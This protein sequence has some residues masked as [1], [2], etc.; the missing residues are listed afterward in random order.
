MFGFL[1]GLFKKEVSN[2]YPIWSFST[3]KENKQA[4]SLYKRWVYTAISTIAT[5]VAALDYAL[6]KNDKKINHKYLELINYDLLEAITTHLLLLWISV[7]WKVKTGNNILQLVVLRPDRIFKKFDEN[8]NVIGFEY[9]MNWKT[10]FFNKEDLII[11][12]NFDPENPEDELSAKSPVEAGIYSILLDDF[13]TKWNF[14]FFKQWWKIGLVL[15]TDKTLPKDLLERLRIQF[16]EA[17]KGLENA[18]KP[19]VLEGGMK[20]QTI[21]SNQKDM[22]FSELKRI[23]RDEILSYFKVPKAI[24]WLGEWNN[25]NIRIFEKIY[26]KRTIYPIAK[27]IENSF[28]KDLFVGVWEFKFLNVV[29]V[30]VDNL[31]ENFL[32]W[33]ITLN[34]YRQKIGYKPLKDGDVLRIWTD[35]VPVDIQ[36]ES[37]TSSINKKYVELGLKAVKTE[38]VGTEEWAEKK[39]VKFVKRADS[40]EEIFAKRIKRI[41]ARQ[42]KDILKELNSWKTLSS[43]SKKDLAVYFVDKFKNWLLWLGLLKKPVTDYAKNE[44][45]E[46]LKDIWKDPKEF[47][48]PEKDKQL[49]D[50]IRTYILNLADQVDKTTLEEISKI[51][52]QGLTNGVWVDEIKNQVSEKFDSYLANGVEKIVRTETT[53]IANQQSYQARKDAGI[54]YKKWYTAKDERT[55]PYC[56]SFHNKVVEIDKNFAWAGDVVEGKLILKNDIGYPPLH[57]N[58]RCIIVPE[59]N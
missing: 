45:V 46:N 41:F 58:C 54:T 59:V 33:A 14:Q 36:Q 51:I 53:R 40:F 20:I 22:D 37:K 34:E 9:L 10:Y 26:A 50:A 5:D 48:T 23:V 16:Q 56:S 11:I 21:A 24:V 38:L 55:C 25:L 12:K 6:F 1:K 32:A 18:H 27:K 42:K 3:D 2:F 28:N 35:L 29:P 15:E 57:P 43:Y 52:S 30:D 7:L 13:S 4:I 44:Y 47:F 39:R 31:K 8:G 19:I 17:N 49:D